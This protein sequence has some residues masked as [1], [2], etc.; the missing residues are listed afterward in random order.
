MEEYM[1]KLG[2]FVACLDLFTPM[3][4]FLGQHAK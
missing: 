1:K 4:E 2:F 3:A